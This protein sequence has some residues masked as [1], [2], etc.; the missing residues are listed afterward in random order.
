M[1]L[2]DHGWAC[3]GC[4]LCC[5]AFALGPLDPSF[6]EV[7]GLDELARF[8]PWHLPRS[9]G[10]GVW[11]AHDEK[12]CAFLTAE[13]CAV[14][15]GLGARAK[16]WMC[17]LFPFYVSLRADGVAVTVRPACP[18]LQEAPLADLEETVALASPRPLR[19]PVPLLPGAGVSLDAWYRLEPHL[20][21]RE[22]AGVRRVLCMATGRSL[23]SPDPARW[24]EAMEALTGRLRRVLEPVVAL[25]PPRPGAGEA[26][27]HR[28][29]AAALELLSGDPGEREQ[30]DLSL[31]PEARRW[32]VRVLSQALLD[33]RILVQG[34]LLGGLGRL[35]L[36]LHLAW[37]G[38]RTLEQAA[39]NLARWSIVADHPALLSAMGDGSGLLVE[40]GIH[41][42]RGNGA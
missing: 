10:E 21:G 2:P 32:E 30:G 16:P 12:G 19:E 18:S 9:P 6:L 33:R 38:A 24:W 26:E 34:S 42:R 14:H 4:G 1:V 5:R 8:R 15:R 36:D 28:L 22:L 31:S 11:L 20:V 35:S 39:W 13:G 37:R 17:R 25:P 29:C 23:P 7:P 40:M 41:T 3:M 27:R